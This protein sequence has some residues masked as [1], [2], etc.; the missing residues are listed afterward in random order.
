MQLFLVVA[1]SVV[2]L[3]V[4]APQ[5]GRRGGYAHHAGSRFGGVEAGV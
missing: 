2:A 4:A 3:A 1:L 5:Y